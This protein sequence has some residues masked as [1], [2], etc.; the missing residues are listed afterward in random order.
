MPLSSH[1][2]TT[3]SNSWGAVKVRTLGSEVRV[4]FRCSS[5]GPTLHRLRTIDCRNGGCRGAEIDETRSGATTELEDRLTLLDV[6]RL[7]EL[8]AHLGA[9][10]WQPDDAGE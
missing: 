8:A 9:S 1:A 3:A 10:S 2:R 6:E 7:D 5:T 4:G